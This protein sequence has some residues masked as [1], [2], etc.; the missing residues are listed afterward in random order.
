M[1][2]PVP[3]S[4][5]VP[6]VILLAASTALVLRPLPMQGRAAFAYAQLVAM[7]GIYMGFAI[8]SLDRAEIVQQGDWTALVV[9]WLIALAFIFGG[10]AA[11]RSSR[12][13]LLGAL[14]LAHGGVDFLHLIL[15]GDHAPGWYAVACILYDAIAGVI[16]IWFLSG[17]GEPA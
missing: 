12:P 15:G 3:Y 1:D 2:Q 5:L 7:V 9:E 10:L 14:I 6:I 16:A 17:R 11:L 8:A 13:W 4:V